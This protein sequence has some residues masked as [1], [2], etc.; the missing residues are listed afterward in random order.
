M[1]KSQ[2]AFDSPEGLRYEVMENGDLIVVSGDASQLLEL[3]AK[4]Y[5]QLGGE[6]WKEEE[7]KKLLSQDE[8]LRPRSMAISLRLGKLY[9]ETRNFS[10][11]SEYRKMILAAIKDAIG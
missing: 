3:G 11:F 10:G 5:M 1:P 2:E 8:E 6:D 7:A 9:V 4:I